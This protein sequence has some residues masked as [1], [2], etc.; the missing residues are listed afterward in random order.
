MSK[1]PI[2][3]VLA[4]LLALMLIVAS[5]SS[6]DDAADNNTG[7]APEGDPIV[8][9]IQTDKTGGA[10]EYNVQPTELVKALIEQQNANGGVLGR[11]IQVVEGNDESDPTKAPTV[12]QKL[13]DEGA[14]AVFFHSGGAAII[15]AK[16][17]TVQLGLPVFA[18]TNSTEAVQGPP[19]NDV[20]YTLGL[21]TGVWSKVYCNGM[22][23]AGIKRIGILMD[24]SP[25]IAGFSEGVL[26]GMDCIEVVT[27]ETAPVD[28]PDLAPQIARLQKA[29]IDAVMTFAL[30]NAFEIAAQN[31]LHQQM[32]DMPRFMTA[33][34]GNSP[35]AWKIADPGAL[36]GAVFM[37]TVDPTNERTKDV[38]AQMKELMGEDFPMNGFTA[39]TW[40]AY[41]LLIKAIE[42]AGSD[43]PAAINEAIQNISG[44]E[45]SFGLPGLTI[46]YDAT[47]RNGPDSD[48]GLLL[49]QF[50][51]DNTPSKVYDHFK[52]TC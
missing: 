22:S 19:D 52:S 29:D 50:G 47:K 40:D 36:D 1:R 35:D 2:T 3:G 5:C 7:P 9:G 15:Q 21:P 14:R 44:Y 33:V 10:A 8:I 39:Q 42:D 24:D 30:G 46:S 11:P 41:H 45:A 17:L 43:D 49:V 23:N 28:A 20:I 16:P 51:A 48:C 31:A 37:A 4:T 18:S 12:F 26:E 6:S 25:T 34:F 27:T 38:E 13:Y 32:P